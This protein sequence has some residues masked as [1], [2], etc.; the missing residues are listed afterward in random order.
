MY[1]LLCSLGHKA[2][3][4]QL[5][6]SGIR[7]TLPVSTLRSPAF[8]Q[9][10]TQQNPKMVSQHTNTMIKLVGSVLS[11]LKGWMFKYRNVAQLLQIRTTSWNNRYESKSKLFLTELLQLLILLQP[12]QFLERENS[13]TC[14][15]LLQFSVS[16]PHLLQSAEL[17]SYNTSAVLQT[18]WLT[19]SNLISSCFWTQQ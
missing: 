12:R 11:K 5:G 9:W 1:I 18:A 15:R 17:G 14:K 19:S 8:I 16:L 7:Q 10:F 4:G 3:G 2:Q 6:M 13:H